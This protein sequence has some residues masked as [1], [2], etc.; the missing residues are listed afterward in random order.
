VIVIDAD[1][2]TRDNVEYEEIDTDTKAEIKEGIVT[3]TEISCEVGSLKLA[4]DEKG[5]ISLRKSLRD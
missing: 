1:D 2:D 4:S 3:E 5:S